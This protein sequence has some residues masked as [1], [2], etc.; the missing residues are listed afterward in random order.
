MKYHGSNVFELTDNEI[1]ILVEITHHFD[2]FGN[3]SKVAKDIKSNTTTVRNV[4]DR[5]KKTKE[6]VVNE[7]Y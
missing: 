5:F 1:N 3:K 2:V 4:I 6:V 7:S